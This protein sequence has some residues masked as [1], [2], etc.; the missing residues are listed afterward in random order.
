M[1]GLPIFNQKK[2]NEGKDIEQSTAV[3]QSAT[4]QIVPE[5]L[6]P[7]TPVP[8]GDDSSSVP[9]ASTQPV[10]S[11]GAPQEPPKDEEPV[12]YQTT[13]SDDDSSNST[14]STAVF[15]SNEEISLLEEKVRKANLPKELNAKTNGMLQRLKKMT[16]GGNYTAEFEPVSEYINWIIQIPFGKFT[17][18]DLSIDNA[19]K[20]LDSHHY[21]LNVVKERLLEYLAILNLQSKGNQAA[22]DKANLN[23]DMS[24]EMM[25]LQGNSSHAPI[26][27][28]VGIQGVGKTTMAK[29]IAD[30]LG[31]KFIRVALGAIGNVTEIRG[32]SRGE[33]DAE[34]GQIVKSLIRTGVMNPLILLDEIDKTSSASGLRADLMA[35]LLEILDPE[36]NSTFMD[37]YLDFPVDLSQC[38]FITTSN[39]LGGISAALLDRL[40]VVRFSSYNDDEK[41]HIAR[42]YLLPKVRK[43]TGLTEDQL[44]FDDSVWPLVIR[45]LGFDAG[46]RQLERTLMDLARKVA[47]QIVKGTAKGVRI[48]PENFR[49]FIPETIGIMS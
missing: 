29:S 11:P 31:R 25:R 19:I 45:P 26:L 9:P 30:A 1:L 42:D 21:G 35:A 41:L 46:V 13:Y 15:D 16:A 12:V 22:S 7:V 17:K 48:T 37:K 32:R 23:I 34:P 8:S 47:F 40:E 38:I 14:S 5:G 28:F 39:N 33:V 6:A 49:Q 36:Q 18:D 24:K 20:T 44:S 2:D 3:S 27:C 4:H 10:V 43:A